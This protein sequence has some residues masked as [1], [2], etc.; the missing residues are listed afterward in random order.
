MNMKEAITSRHS[1]RQYLEQPIE[2]EKREQIAA[3][4]QQCNAESGLH[5]QA[6]Y[7]DSAC[8]PSLLAHSGCSATQRIILC[9]QA[10]PQ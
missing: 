1:V 7:D 9:W 8:F 4:I 10:A 3:M 6:V 2:P 5:I